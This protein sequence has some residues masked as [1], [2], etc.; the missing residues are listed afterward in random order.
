MNLNVMKVKNLSLFFCGM[1]LSFQ[2]VLAQWSTSGSNVYLTSTTYNVGIGTA[3]PNSKLTVYSPGA[4]SLLTIGKAVTGFSYVYLGTSADT[5]GYGD[6][7]VIKSEGSTW[8]NLAI[9]RYGGNV[10]IGT[11]TP[12]YTLDVNGATNTSNLYVTNKIGINTVT[13]AYNLDVN[14]VINASS[15]YINGA[16][17]AGGGSQWTTSSSNIYFLGGNVGIG[18]NQPNSFKLAVEGKIGAREVVVTLSNP[19]PDY[20]FT[21]SF[22]LPSL[23]E[24]EHFIKVNSHLPGVPS[25]S[26][27]KQDGLAVGEMNAILLKKIEE[28]TLYVIEL[29]KKNQEQDKVIEE[30]VQEKK[31]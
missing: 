9:N 11:A 14:G 20:V 2:T 5:G 19:W 21:P 26:E 3:T 15:I 16:P 8:G 7:Q 10:G 6:L 31:N 28:L 29:E 23:L 4:R 24:V 25:A 17:F 1:L 12:S 13:P 18:T 27:I 30:L 22:K